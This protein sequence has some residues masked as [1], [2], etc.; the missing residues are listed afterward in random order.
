MPKVQRRGMQY[1][2][3]NITSEC[4]LSAYKMMFTWKGRSANAPEQI[5]GANEA[6]LQDAKAKG[7]DQKDWKPV[8]RAFGLWPVKGGDFSDDWFK[9]TMKD[10]GP[11]LVHGKLELV[12]HSIVVI[13]YEDDFW[14][15]LKMVHYVNPYTFTAGV[16]EPPQPRMSNFEWLRKGVKRNNG[17]D[18][19]I[20]YWTD[21]NT[22][23]GSDGWLVD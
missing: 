17:I 20:Q 12:M 23:G 4:W 16:S 2:A 10:F 11:F 3:Q 1:L 22:A 21:K 7:L 9:G 18:G 8:A 13:G 19:V 14:G 15:T 5:L 6:F